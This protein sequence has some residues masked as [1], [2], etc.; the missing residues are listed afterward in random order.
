MWQARWVKERLNKKHLNLETNIEIL[1]TKGDKVPDLPLAG[2]KGFFTREIEHALLD[3]TIDLAVH[4]LKD[5]P[6]ELPAGLTIGAVTE[7][8]DVRDV[9]IPHPHNPVR[10]LAGQPNGA[11]IATSSLR[12]RCQ[13]LHLYPGVSVIDV[14]GNVNTRMKKLDESDWAGIILA[15]AGV[16]RLG[17]EDRIGE[18]LSAETFLPAV[19]QGALAIEIRED[20]E[21]VRS[22]VLTLRHLPTEYST[23]AERSLLHRL[24]G[25]CQVPIG[26]FGRVIENQV[27]KLD[28][29]VGSLDGQMVVRGSI[30]GEP[31][32]ARRLGEELAEQLLRAGADRILQ[33]IRASRPLAQ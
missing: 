24:E 12:R 31:S 28:A 23:T 5:L 26:T 22:I 3:R 7:R 13:V 17:W 27:L 11:V 16:E 19:G 25:G 8:G 6:T 21:A 20:D 18:T 10:T 33:A 1:K 9:F 15:R 14:R 29:L 4:S 30:H 2:D 32:N